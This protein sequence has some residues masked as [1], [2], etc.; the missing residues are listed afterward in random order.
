MNDDPLTKNQ[1]KNTR[2]SGFVKNPEK[3]F[4]KYV[5]FLIESG[6]DMSTYHINLVEEEDLPHNIKTV[7]NIGFRSFHSFKKNSI[8]LKNLILIINNIRELQKDK[9]EICIEAVHRLVMKQY[10]CSRCHGRGL[11][12]LMFITNK[13]DEKLYSKYHTYYN[14][15]IKLDNNAIDYKSYMTDTIEKYYKF[16]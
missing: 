13:I 3:T 15:F 11:V 14:Y 6:E 12:Y 5:D 10:L 2:I 4:L 1:G 16:V 7:I 8:L 9:Y